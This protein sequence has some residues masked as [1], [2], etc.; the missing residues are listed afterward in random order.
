[1]ITSITVCIDAWSFECE[2]LRIQQVAL[3]YHVT[4]I[5]PDA[6]APSPS[7]ATRSP[8]SRRRS[9]TL[10]KTEI[11][12]HFCIKIVKC[13]KTPLFSRSLYSVNV[14][15]GT[16]SGRWCPPK[17]RALQP[18]GSCDQP[19][20]R[21][22]VSPRRT[23]IITAPQA[24][25]GE[26]WPAERGKFLCFSTCCCSATPGTPCPDAGH[27]IQGGLGEAGEGPAKG[28]AG[29]DLEGPRRLRR[30]TRS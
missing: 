5:L 29:Q 25:S 3:K 12:L 13:R 14:Q 8:G 19:D 2:V 24:A 11:S 20:A 1:M 6:Y 21:L 4:L 26:P 18:S 22:S 30:G 17:S 15:T 7:L 9:L 27:P 23:L 28:G 16:A 10:T